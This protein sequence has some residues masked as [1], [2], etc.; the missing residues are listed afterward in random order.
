MARLAALNL[1]ARCI[2]IDTYPAIGIVAF[3]LLPIDKTRVAN[4]MSAASDIAIAARSLVDGARSRVYEDIDGVVVEVPYA[5]TQTLKLS[6][7]M[8]ESYGGRLAYGISR[9]GKPLAIDLSNPST[10]HV[11]IAGTTGSGK[12]ALMHSMMLGLS[13][14]RSE[15]T[16]FVW[17]DPKRFDRSWLVPVLGLAYCPQIEDA[18][19]AVECL[20]FLVRAMDS[21]KYLHDGRILIFIDELADLIE[22]GGDE[23]K[24]LLRRIAQKGREY[25]IH[26]ILATQKPLMKILDPLL[27]SNIPARLVLRVTTA[28]D[29][30]TASGLEG[31]G[32]ELLPGSGHGYAVVNGQSSRFIAAMPDD[33]GKAET[34]QANPERVLLAPVAQ[35][36]LQT[37]A[38]IKRP[39][40]Y[41]LAE[42]VAL[43]RVWNPKISMTIAQ[44]A[45]APPGTGGGF[46]AIKEAWGD[47]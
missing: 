45:L 44:K 23:A 11:L 39:D 34:F 15:N 25:R 6:K 37:Q 30:K 27:V 42:R 7:I 14:P 10:P 8:H 24:T 17:V 18:N 35:G 1:N 33:Y 32:A 20:R 47:E 41:T 5:Q 21:S 4:L 12:T 2:D 3:K 31:V 46:Y 22:V 43:L 19:A 38:P 28:I 26:L 29:S 13:H 40:D 9:D 36:P 16:R